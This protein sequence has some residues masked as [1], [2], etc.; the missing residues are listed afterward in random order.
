MYIHGVLYNSSHVLACVCVQNHGLKADMDEARIYIERYE[1]SNE[2]MQGKIQV[3]L[4]LYITHQ[5][6][7]VILALYRQTFCNGAHGK[8]L[9]LIFPDDDAL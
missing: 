1:A 8:C 2:R 5:L 7:C 3:S 9:P 4:T 6:L